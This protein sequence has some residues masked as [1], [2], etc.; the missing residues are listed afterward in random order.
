MVTAANWS[1]LAGWCDCSMIYIHD[2][3]STFWALLSQDKNLKMYSKSY[4]KPMQGLKYRGDMDIYT[5][6]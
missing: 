5:C 6:L 2:D 1:V 3:A 4:W